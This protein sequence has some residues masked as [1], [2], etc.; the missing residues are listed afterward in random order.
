[1]AASGASGRRIRQ[2]RMIFFHLLQGSRLI[3]SGPSRMLSKHEWLPIDRNNETIQ[4]L[5]NGTD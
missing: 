2:S 1:M 4:F 3:V 5:H